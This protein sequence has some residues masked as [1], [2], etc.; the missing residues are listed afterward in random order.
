MGHV[1]QGFSISVLFKNESYI[2]VYG[3]CKVL[4]ENCVKKFKMIQN[5][6][7]NLIMIMTFDRNDY[8]LS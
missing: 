4:C 3:G 2:S 5:N 8:I 7:K 1:D 6:V